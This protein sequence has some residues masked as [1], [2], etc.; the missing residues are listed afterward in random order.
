MIG[1]GNISQSLDPGTSASVD[2][3]YDAN[4][5]SR[6]TS[7]DSDTTVYLHFKI[8]NAWNIQLGTVTAA[9][10][11]TAPAVVI[12]Q[13]DSNGQSSIVSK[14]LHFTLPVSQVLQG[15]TVTL[16]GPAASPSGS[17]KY[18]EDDTIKKYPTLDLKLPRAS[19]TKYGSALMQTT[20]YTINPGTADY[21]AVSDLAVGD[22]YINT[23]LAAVHRIASIDPNNNSITT[24]Y[25]G[26]MQLAIPTITA[27]AVNPYDASGNPTTPTITTSTTTSPVNAWNV[28]VNTPIAPVFV[29]SN[30]SGFVASTATGEISSRAS[31]QNVILTLKI[32][33]G[34]KFTTYIRAADKNNIKST[35]LDGDMY[36]DSI[37]AL[38][39]YSGNGTSGIWESAGSLK[40]DSFQV[41]NSSAIVVTANDLLPYSGSFY[42]KIGAY[43]D[44]NYPSIMASYKLNE[45][46]NVNYQIDTDVYASHWLFKASGGTWTGS[47]LT[48]DASNSIIVDDWQSE[49]DDSKAYS[50]TL[51]NELR[52]T[53]ANLQSQI[54]ALQTEVNKGWGV[55]TDNGL[56][57]YNPE[58]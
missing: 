51:I 26:T 40:G 31:N 5:T 50:V 32:P 33:R 19:M 8:P 41:K 11:N 46:I 47:Q 6:K 27:S 43:I 16:L 57:P 13:T 1:L 30:D 4:S 23:T 35:S 48:G 21:G 20:N 17:Y 14:Y 28:T 42:E 15:V 12:N 9:A 10:P 2:W 36:L 58:E 3:S 44:A 53:I 45:I 24:E 54:T 38:Y 52:G 49:T 56:V 18:A 29:K 39:V 22:Y 55:M 7:T 37:G 25:R 34:T